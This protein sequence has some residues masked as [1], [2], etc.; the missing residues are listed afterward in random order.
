MFLARKTCN[1]KNARNNN[2]KLKRVKPNLNITQERKGMELFFLINLN[3]ND[4]L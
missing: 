1:C 4:N 3:S 2:N